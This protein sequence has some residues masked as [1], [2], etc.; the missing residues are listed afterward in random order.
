MTQHKYSKHRDVTNIPSSATKSAEQETRLSEENL[1]SI[2]EDIKGKLIKDDLFGPDINSAIK[3]ALSSKALFDAVSPIYNKFCHK[4]NQ[5]KM[6]EDFYGLLPINPSTFLHCTDANVA[7]LIMIE[8][9]D[10][11]VGFFKIA[12]SRQASNN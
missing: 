6:L 7:N 12:R 11:L 8:I 9:P 5:D 3:K 2:V 10:R 4:K 1:A